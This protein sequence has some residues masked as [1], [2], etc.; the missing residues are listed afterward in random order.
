MKK[1]C[2][3]P[4]SPVLNINMLTCFKFS[5]GCFTYIHITSLD[6]GCFENPYLAL[7]IEFFFGLG[8]RTKL[9]TQVAILKKL[10]PELAI[11]FETKKVLDFPDPT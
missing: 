6:I 10:L 11:C 5:T 2:L 1:H 8:I 7:K 9:L 3:F 4:C